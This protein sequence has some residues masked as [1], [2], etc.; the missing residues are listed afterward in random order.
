[1]YE[2]HA[3]GVLTIDSKMPGASGI[4]SECKKRAAEGWR[5]VQA[6][7]DNQKHN[8]HVLIFEREVLSEREREIRMQT[9]PV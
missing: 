3:I 8:R 6:Y 1:M 4:S 7:S 9:A 5:L 2:Y